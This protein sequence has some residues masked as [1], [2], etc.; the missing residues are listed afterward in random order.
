M[1]DRQSEPEQPEEAGT[2]QGKLTELAERERAIDV[3]QE[4]YKLL[5]D[6]APAWFS[7]ELHERMKAALRILGRW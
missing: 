6:Y 4:I 1:R 5:E 2:V 3:F 7:E